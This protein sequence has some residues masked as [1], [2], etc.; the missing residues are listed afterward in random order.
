MNNAININLHASFLSR[1]SLKY[2]LTVWN[3]NVI[4]LQFFQAT[5]RKHL[6]IDLEI[7]TSSIQCFRICFSSNCHTS[8]LMVKEGNQI[9][10]FFFPTNGKL[11]LQLEVDLSQNS[12]IYLLP[13][14]SY[15]QQHIMFKNLDVF[16]E[17]SNDTYY[18]KGWIHDNLY[19]DHYLYIQFENSNQDYFEEFP[20]IQRQRPDVKNAFEVDSFL[21]SGFESS[22]H[23]ETPFTLSCYIGYYTID[24]C[25]KFLIHTFDRNSTD[26]TPHIKV[27]GILNPSIECISSP[28]KFYKEQF[29]NFTNLQNSILI[30]NHHLG[31]GADKFIQTKID[32]LFKSSKRVCT[33]EYFPTTNQYK[34]K[35][36]T[37]GHCQEVFFEHLDWFLERATEFLNEIWINELASYPNIENVLSTLSKSIKNSACKVKFYV[38]DYLCICPSIN[39]LNDKNE[40]CFLPAFNICD[41]CLKTRSC[42][43]TSSILSWRKHWNELLINSNE[44]I[45]FSNSSVEY[46]QKIYPEIPDEN[47]KLIPHTIIPLAK[48]N[49]TEDNIITVGLLGGLYPHKGLPIIRQMLDYLEDNKVH[50]RIVLIGHSS[51]P[52]KSTYFTET[53]EYLRKDIVPLTEYYNI[54][55]FFMSS[56]CP[57]TFSYTTS[58]I[59]SMNLPLLSFDLGAQGERVQKYTKGKVIPLD[60][61]TKSIILALE[62]LYNHNKTNEE[63][64]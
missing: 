50:M 58:E 12:Y 19:K 49:I 25:Q 28:R 32:E 14:D 31:G 30:F 7:S 22:L 10:E 8:I 61:P 38:H 57:E 20:L 52:I 47:I 2:N 54:D 60:T 46:I 55:V 48:P 53:G 18:C 51:T 6:K 4:A 21:W 40:Y 3:K 27:D 9:N 33:I 37:L 11:I 29:F 23:V 63:T 64:H 15:N 26:N 35:I 24:G 34:L 39:L 36:Y 42:Q 41:Q 45:C 5:L 17:L 44:I 1:I 59:M 43:E 16:H 13:N 56:I 62:E